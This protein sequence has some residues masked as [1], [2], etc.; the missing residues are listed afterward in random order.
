MAANCPKEESVSLEITPESDGEHSQI[1]QTSQPAQTTDAPDQEAE[2]EPQPSDSGDEMTRG[3]E[4]PTPL[5]MDDIDSEDSI[6]MALNDPNSPIK[7]CLREIKR[8]RK[9]LKRKEKLYN[10]MIERITKEI[11]P[12]SDAETSEKSPSKQA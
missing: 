7:Q 12:L 11:A 4:K 8:L 10:K 2:E 6:W 3:Q 1:V 9:L 5:V